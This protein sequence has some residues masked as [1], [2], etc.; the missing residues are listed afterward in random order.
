MIN[1]LHLQNPSDFASIM[2]FHY[3][4]KYYVVSTPTEKKKK[5]TEFGKHR[6]AFQVALEK[7][8][9]TYVSL[10]HYI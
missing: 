9:F 6:K 5:R 7:F 1:K 8:Q 4:G 10:V 2:H 3:Q